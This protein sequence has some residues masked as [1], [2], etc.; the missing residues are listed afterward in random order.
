MN[1]EEFKVWFMQNLDAMAAR[2]IM[3][4]KTDRARDLQAM[5]NIYLPKLR[6]LESRVA[7]LEA[8]P[9]RKKQTV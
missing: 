5:F 9:K 6:E 1:D 7:A 3:H 8:P 2:G 4:Y